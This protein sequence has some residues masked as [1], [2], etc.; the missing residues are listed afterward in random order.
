M[1]LQSPRI[2]R[3]RGGGEDRNG[4]GYKCDTTSRDIERG[5]RLGFSGEEAQTE[6]LGCSVG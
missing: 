1:K 5:T 6:K 3:E 2:K 4:V